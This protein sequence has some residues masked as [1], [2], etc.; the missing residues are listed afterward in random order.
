MYVFYVFVVFLL[1]LWFAVIS[2]KYADIK[3]FKLI[4]KSGSNNMKLL[5][6]VYS[7]NTS[8][9]KMQKENGCFLKNVLKY[10]VEC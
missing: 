4:M 10:Y 8:F 9:K 3:L 2:S 1:G 7:D 6:V 5:I